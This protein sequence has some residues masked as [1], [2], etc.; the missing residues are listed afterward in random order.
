MTLRFQ[1]R[2]EDIHQLS[3]GTLAMSLSALFEIAVQVLGTLAILIA[4]GAVI[5]LLQALLE[6]VP[7]EHRKLPRASIWF[8]IVPGVYFLTVLLIFSRV[9]ASIASFR[10]SKLLD[11]PR[12][13]EV[14]GWLHAFFGAATLACIW[15]FWQR[16]VGPAGTFGALNKLLIFGGTALLLSVG[17]MITYLQWSENLLHAAFQ[18]PA[19]NKD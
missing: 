9:S 17:C 13:V 3:G 10:R 4:H 2:I 19:A 1:R 15:Y 5:G 14:F 12:A 6:R 16:W 8:L 7:D 18:V 11:W